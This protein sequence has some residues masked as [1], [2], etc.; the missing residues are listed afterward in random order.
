MNSL[1]NRSLVPCFLFAIAVILT[2]PC[3][4]ADLQINTD[5]EGGSARVESVDQA[6]RIV[7]FVPGGDAERGWPCWWA[8]RIDGAEQG[9][10]ITL[11]LGGSDVPVRNNGKNTGVPLAA[12]WAMPGRA[13]Y[14]TDGETWLQT[15]PGHR[16]GSRIHYQVTATGSTLWLAWG[17][18]FTQRHV[19]ALLADAQKTSPAATSFELARTR[20]GY[21]VR[22]LRITEASSGDV[23][24]VWIQARQHAW[25]SGSSWVARGLV[26]WLTG[27]D[28]DA[29]WLRRHA[30]V[31]VVPIM[32]VDNVITGNGGKE[33]N[34]RDHNRD[35]SDQPTYPEVAAAQSRLL[36]FAKA[37]RLALF[38]DLHNPA[39]NDL[40]PFFFMVPDE[41]IGE[42]AR[43]NRNAFL[44]IATARINDPFTLNQPRTTGPRYHPLWRQISDAWVN[45]HGNPHTVAVCLETSWNTPFSNTPGYRKVG[46]QLGQ[47]IAEYMRRPE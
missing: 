33:A 39:A 10:I 2:R 22:G 19:D 31:F 4:S 1:P 43:E 7:H 45:E 29:Q 24:V 9:E 36:E 30:E 38:I 23:P 18:L 28:E 15:D 5:F 20:D 13:A 8:L 6:N 32:D 11:D 34:P 35:W 42:T 44:R 14:S 41:F 37:G 40:Q 17:P 3:S 47:T 46:K 12:V 26:E 27:G 25:E 21:V 16:E